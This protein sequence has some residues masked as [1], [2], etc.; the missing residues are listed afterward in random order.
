MKRNLKQKAIRTL[1]PI[2]RVRWSDKPG[3]KVLIALNN[4]Y[5]EKRWRGLFEQKKLNPNVVFCK[6]RLDIIRHFNAAD[7]CFLYSFGST[8]Q[9]FR[10][11]NKTLYFPVTGKEFLTRPVSENN[12]ILTPE[13]LSAQAIAEYCLATTITFI[14][15]LQYAFFNQKAGKWRQQPILATPYR[16]IDSYRVGILGAGNVGKAIAQIFAL[17][18]CSVS[19]CDKKE[20]GNQHFIEHYFPV[21]EL[22]NFLGNIDILIVALPLTAETEG[23]ITLNELQHL[24]PGKIIV[25]ISRGKIIREKDLIVALKNRIIGGAILDVFEREPL[26]RFSPLWHL[27][28][29]IV[30]PHIAGNINLFAESIMADFIGKTLS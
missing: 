14:R 6:T 26:K 27:D 30:T 12:R 25:N 13:P 15:S 9:S 23:M 22:H 11:Q 1:L 20:I 4:Y 5:T 8:L 29:V 17:N 19:C 3:K 7:I 16:S 10:P 21:T 2:G 24:G 28:N 18:G